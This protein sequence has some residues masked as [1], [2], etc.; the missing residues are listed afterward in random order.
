[1]KKLF[2]FAFLSIVLSQCAPKSQYSSDNGSRLHFIEGFAV[3]SIS[4]QYAREPV[5]KICSQGSTTPQLEQMAIDSVLI[6]F[7]AVRIIDDKVTSNIEISCQNP[8]L[9]ITMTPGSSRS[10]AYA[11]NAVYFIQNPFGE[12]VHELGHALIGLGDTYQ[13]SSAGQCRSNQPQSNMCWGA[14]GPRT[15]LNRYSGLWPDD[16]EGA[17]IQHRKLFPD[18]TP[19]TNATQID[20]EA[21]LDIAS[22]WGEKLDGKDFEE[23]EPQTEDPELFSDNNNNNNNQGESQP[24]AFDFPKTTPI[25]IKLN[26]SSSGLDLA[27]S[28]N[29]Q[30]GVKFAVICFEDLATCKSDIQLGRDSHN[31]ILLDLLKETTSKTIFSKNILR[32]ISNRTFINVF[33]SNQNNQL[34]NHESF[35]IRPR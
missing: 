17:Q 2:T 10:Y 16:I 31:F 4:L 1:M 11:G 27:I 12:L 15:D 9:T 25:A 21:P 19:P 29:K 13:G 33:L 26:Q 3:N 8:H 14:Y 34:V 32:T 28:A 5:F 23:S 7:S 20:A 18:S 6:W 30:D 24:Q 22:T 35:T